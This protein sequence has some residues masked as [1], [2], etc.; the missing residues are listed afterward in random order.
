MVIQFLFW[1]IRERR[2]WVQ[3]GMKFMTSQ[4]NC[5]KDCS[6]DRLFWHTTFC[7]HLKLRAQ[8]KYVKLCCF[9]ECNL[10]FQTGVLIFCFLRKLHKAQFYCPCT[11]ITVCKCLRKSPLFRWQCFRKKHD[12]LW[13][14]PRKLK[15][16]LKCKSHL[17]LLEKQEVA[18]LYHKYYEQ[19]VINLFSI[20][21]WMYWSKAGICSVGMFECCF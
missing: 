6:V 15:S 3:R 7:V 20:C 11:C 19:L 2:V 9:P 5:L 1:K 4:G 16:G 13:E 10:T 18:L 21:S 12:L 8:Q 14:K 17:S